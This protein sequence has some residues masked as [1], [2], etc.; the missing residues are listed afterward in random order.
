MLSSKI[1][2]VYIQTH[3]KHTKALSVQNTEFWRLKP[4]E[5]KVTTGI[6]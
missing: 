3:T 4:V 5:H 6:K 1:T 2:T